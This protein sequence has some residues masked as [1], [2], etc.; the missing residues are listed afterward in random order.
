MTE[1]TFGVGQQVVVQTGINAGRV[2]TIDSPV[3]EFAYQVRF[4]DSEP[5]YLY[6]ARDL[7]LVPDAAPVPVQTSFPSADEFTF[8]RTYVAE[9]VDGKLAF[10]R[11]ILLRVSDAS[12]WVQVLVPEGTS[13]LQVFAQEVYEQS[14]KGWQL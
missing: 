12:G 1:T 11:R 9:L 4:D 8:E 6:P 3:S 7:K 5:K 13:N 14:K 2:G 10:N